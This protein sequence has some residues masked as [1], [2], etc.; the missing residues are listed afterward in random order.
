MS[1]M[2]PTEHQLE[3]AFLAKMIEELHALRNTLEVDGF[4]VDEW[5]TEQN[6]T[7][8][9]PKRV[10]DGPVVITAI[11]AAWPVTSTSAIINLGTPGRSIP[12]PPTLGLFNANDLKIQT[13]I[14]DIA[15]NLTIAPAGAAYI[16]FYGYADLQQR[17]RV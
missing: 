4:V 13:G 17:D 7:V 16:N 10:Y 1:H 6:A 2:V 3:K 9:T 5:G 14:D 12:L 15:R 11:L 8:I